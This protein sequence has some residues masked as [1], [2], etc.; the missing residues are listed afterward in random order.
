MVKVKCCYRWLIL[1]SLVL[2]SAA[3]AESIYSWVDENGVTHFST[4]V[5]KSNASFT[6][7]SVADR[8]DDLQRKIA[9]FTPEGVAVVSIEKKGPRVLLTGKSSSA[10]SRQKFSELLVANGF[11][12]VLPRHTGA[13]RASKELFHFYILEPQTKTQS[14]GFIKPAKDRKKQVLSD[15]DWINQ[16][17]AEVPG[18]ILISKFKVIDGVLMVKGSTPS[19]N[20]LA[21]LMQSISKYKLGEPTL[22]KYKGKQFVIMVTP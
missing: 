1:I 12:G 19:Q 10:K 7:Y 16:V 13:A 2:G 17:G 9:G 4:Q 22:T 8:L 3:Q 15:A 5:I 6:S 18:E 21:E 20:Y 11:G 14:L